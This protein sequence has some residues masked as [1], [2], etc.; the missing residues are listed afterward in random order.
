MSTVLWHSSLVKTIYILEVDLYSYTKS[1]DKAL[2]E[3]PAV[4][5][6]IENQNAKIMFD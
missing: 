6:L 2:L 5:F 1:F 3:K 4:L